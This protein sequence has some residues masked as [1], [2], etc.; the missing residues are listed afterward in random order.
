MALK[1]GWVSISNPFRGVGGR[2]S[3]ECKASYKHS[4]ECEK[5]V[6]EQAR[7][8]G[9]RHRWETF[10]GTPARAATVGDIAR[11]EARETARPTARTE[12]RETTRDGSKTDSKGTKQGRQQDRQQ[13]RQ[14]EQKQGRKQEPPPSRAMVDIVPGVCPFGG[15][16]LGVPTV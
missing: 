14:Q 3:L 13:G 4:S 15:W 5:R 7:R 10:K 11:T 16:R 12:A 6:D 1:F 9:V 8:E 2:H